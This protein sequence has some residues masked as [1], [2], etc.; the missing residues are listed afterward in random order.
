MFDVFKKR[1]N[2]R[3]VT[4]SFFLVVWAR[5]L[6]GVKQ[7]LKTRRDIILI[8]SW[9]VMLNELVTTFDNYYFMYRVKWAG[10]FLRLTAYWNGIYIGYTVCFRAISNSIVPQPR[11]FFVLGLRPRTKKCLGFGTILLDIVLKHTV[12]PLHIYLFIYI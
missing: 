11:H 2:W 9:C 10:D 5:S 3:N 1:L 6:L 7:A 8:T 12:Y 4:A